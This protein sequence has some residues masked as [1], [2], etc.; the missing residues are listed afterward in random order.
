M[1]TSEKH[2]LYG[3]EMPPH[4]ENIKPWVNKVEDEVADILKDAFLKISRLTY[5]KDGDEE[6]CQDA[7]EDLKEIAILTARQHGIAIWNPEADT[8]T[9]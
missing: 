9:F 6:A 4:I 7:A 5:G 2:F 1:K 8:Y 3:D